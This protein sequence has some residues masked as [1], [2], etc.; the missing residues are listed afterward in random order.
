MVHPHLQE[1]PDLVALRLHVLSE[2]SLEEELPLQPYDLGVQLRL[3][4]PQ[5]VKPVF[6]LAL[7]GLIVELDVPLHRQLQQRDF[8]VQF[9]VQ[10]AGAEPCALDEQPLHKVLNVGIL[11]TLEEVVGCIVQR[12]LVRIL[13]HGL[14]QLERPRLIPGEV[15][16]HPPDEFEYADQALPVDGSDELEVVIVEILVGLLLSLRC[17]FG[18]FV[19]LLGQLLAF[20]VGT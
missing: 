10:V 7:E 4:F 14:S 9:G 1:G 12:L 11:Q 5:V 15:E 18:L 16:H 3:L 17:P 13:G 6:I 19:R 20:H 8:T 2:L